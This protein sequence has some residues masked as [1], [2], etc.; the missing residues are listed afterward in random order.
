SP[1]FFPGDVDL[2]L[3]VETPQRERSIAIADQIVEW[4]QQ[5]RS[6][7]ELSGLH[8]LQQGDVFGMDIPIAFQ[9]EVD[10]HDRSFS[11]ELFPDAG[12]SVVSAA[13]K[14]VV[15]LFAGGAPEGSQG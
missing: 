10:R 12:E 11:L 2:E 4:R 1:A 8:R 6:R 3:E 15:D 5:R 13:N 9:S 14:V 7:F